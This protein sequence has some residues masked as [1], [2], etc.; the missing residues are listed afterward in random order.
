MESERSLKWPSSLSLVRHDV[1]SYN[2]SKLA[3]QQDPLYQR[4]L[5]SYRN[6]H[7]S[8]ETIKLAHEV[9]QKFALGVGNADTPLDR[10]AGHQAKAVGEALREKISLPDVIFVSPY[11]RTRET[12]ANMIK[13]WPELAEV[14][15]LEEER[16]REQDMGTLLIYNDWK[17]FSTLYPDQKILKEI[18]GSY[19]YRFPQG[20]NIPDVRERIRSWLTTLTRDFSSKHVLAITHHL[21]ILSV[22]ANLERLDAAEFIRLD[23]EEKPINCG[24]TIY[25]ADPNQGAQGKLLLTDYNLKLY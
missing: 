21:T 2:A 15:T 25:T 20:E 4:F 23:N 24:V 11:L 1:S 14:K 7:T 16:I 19:W 17:V 9:A 6:D 3:K 12:L 5:D 13:G 8:P 10:E 18:D 22:R